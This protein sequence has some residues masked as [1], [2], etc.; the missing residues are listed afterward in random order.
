MHRCE[1]KRI[2]AC[3]RESS[4]LEAEPLRAAKAKC[5]SSSP[6]RKVC[7]QEPPRDLVV[8]F[9]SSSP[10]GLP[11][12]SSHR[13][14]NSNTIWRLRCALPSSPASGSASSKNVKSPNT[15]AVRGLQQSSPA[16]K[17]SAWPN[18][19]V[20]LRANGIARCPAAAHSAALHFAA[21]GHRAL[22]LAPGYLER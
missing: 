20:N 12:S 10:Q 5:W 19:S 6:P 4:S 14:R 21:A 3:R 1:I 22:P 11:I 9:C 18:H 16:R 17:G 8:A 13:Q 15:K 2:S 7:F